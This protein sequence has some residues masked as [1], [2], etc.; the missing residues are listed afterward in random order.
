[1]RHRKQRGKLERPAG[2]RSALMR[3]QVTSL[4][5]H[6]KI[7]TTDAKAKVLRRVA[8]RMITLGKRGTLHARRRAL[9]VIRDR[10]VAAKLFDEL[11][12]RYAERPGGYT[13]VLK[14]RQRVGDAA[15][16]SIVEL[17]DRGAPAAPAKE[18]KAPAK[19]AAAPKPQK[20][21]AEAKPEKATREKK[22]TAKPA[23]PAKGGASKGE[24][25]G[26]GATPGGAKK[27]GRAP[28]APK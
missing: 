8:D 5:D 15:P 27:T 10:D 1:M 25:R 18:A 16:M 11:A 26:R 23:K 6:E 24:G 28:R 4:L 14:V 13:R 21:K 12:V 7:E 19:R 22:P 9:A 3:N 2:H 20:K 17:V